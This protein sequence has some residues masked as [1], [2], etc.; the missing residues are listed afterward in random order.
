MKQS[1]FLLLSLFH[2]VNSF[3]VNSRMNTNIAAATKTTTISSKTKYKY[4]NVSLQAAK[5]TNDEFWEA[6][7]RMAG[8]MS[9]SVN[10]EE[11]RVK[12]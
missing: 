7:R 3:S 11:Q 5:L 10:E 12:T 9:D 2:A 6:Q 1:L 8:E 4:S